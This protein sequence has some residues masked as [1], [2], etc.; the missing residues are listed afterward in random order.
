[1]V[2]QIVAIEKTCGFLKAVRLRDDWIAKLRK[3]IQV[4]DALASVQIEGSS[5]T[6]KRAFEL[7]E[8]LSDDAEGELRDSE[9]EFLN[10]LRTF[11]AIDGF[12]DERDAVLTKG[13]LLNVHQSIVRGVR[14][15][16]RM[17]GEFRR[18]DVE[19]GDVVNGEKTVHHEPL[20]WH[21][22]E[23]EVRG[24]LEWV[25]C[26]KA[27]GSADTADTWIH[28]TIVAGIAQHR[29]AWI[30]PFVDGNGR[31][32]R[33]FT[34]LILYQ[35]GYDFKYLF[36]LSQYYNSNRNKYYEALRTADQAGDYTAWLEYFLGG[37]SMQMVK[38]EKRAIECASGVETTGSTPP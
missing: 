34:T 6:L 5:L 27:K 33:M 30:H 3:E 15:S 12:R 35:R 18:E 22:V 14:G 4:E 7:A 25:E 23:D 37:L 28:P 1:M 13:D 29:L 26:G 16:L 19:V 21:E 36:N 32:A 2:R 8:D 9:R 24:L 20:A 11:E 17:P 10:Y 38:I 31:T